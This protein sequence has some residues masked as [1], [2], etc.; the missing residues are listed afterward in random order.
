MALNTGVNFMSE[1]RFLENIDMQKLDKTIR[2]AYRKIVELLYSKKMGGEFE[3][4]VIFFVLTS[5]RLFFFSDVKYLNERV[6]KQ[7]SE[8]YMDYID[9]SIKKPKNDTNN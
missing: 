8:S 6:I 9:S 2:N 5:L 4:E 7:L 3:K 1:E